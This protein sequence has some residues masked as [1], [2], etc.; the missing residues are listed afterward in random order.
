MSIADQLSPVLAAREARRAA[1]ESERT[2]RD[3]FIV[4]QFAVLCASFDA[5]LR[6]AL[7][8]DS[9]ITITV[10]PLN[11]IVQGRSF[12]VLTVD[13]WSVVGTFNGAPQTVAF[14]P[15]LDFREPDQ[16]GLVEC[17]LD[18]RYVPGRT[19]ADRVAR[20]LME[21]GVQLRGRSVASLQ[22]PSGQNTRELKAADLEQA[23]TAWWLR[24]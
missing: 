22:V 1:I 15:R 17:A 21:Q 11:H 2:T 6:Q 4:A 20:M 24:P 3:A 13:T 10:T 9:R 23:F 19:P 12:A 14:T 18:F 5:M 16:F 7:G 8:I